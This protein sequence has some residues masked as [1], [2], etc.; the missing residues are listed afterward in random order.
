V[1][2]FCAEEAGEGWWRGNLGV[3]VWSLLVGLSSIGGV[4]LG[5][6]LCIYGIVTG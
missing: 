5:D 1:E 4:G 3:G 2:A 6:R